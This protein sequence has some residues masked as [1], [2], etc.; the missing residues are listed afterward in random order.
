MQTILKR[1]IAG[2]IILGLTLV[3][4]VGCGA[5]PVPTVDQKALEATITARLIATQTASAPTTTNTPTA[6]ATPTLT[7]T[8][9]S[10]PTPAVTSTLTP[11]ATPDI[12]SRIPPKKAY[13]HNHK[14]DVSYDKIRDETVVSID[15]KVLLGATPN[16]ILAVYW[17]KG[18]TIVVPD[19]IDFNFGSSSDTWQFLR[20]SSVAWLV[21]DNKRFSYKAI[22]DGTVGSGYVIE[23]IDMSIPLADFL[24]IVNAK[25]VE[26]QVST[27]QFA[28]TGEQLEALKDFA[29]RM[30]P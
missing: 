29:S 2:I 8:P 15:S 7:A 17:N 16:H 1:G 21:D 3:L 12:L 25:K 22:H 4:I 24:D 28:L 5:A 9:T 18:Q 27:Y 10:T 14:V 20:I 13:N 6:T 23:W 11:T 19:T 30:N 26:V